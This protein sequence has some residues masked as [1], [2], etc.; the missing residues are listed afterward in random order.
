LSEAVDDGADGSPA[1]GAEVV[2]LGPVPPG[3][4]P[5][6]VEAQRYESNTDQTHFRF[7]ATTAPDGTWTATPI[8]TNAV[9]PTTTTG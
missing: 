5:I 1:K 7:V 6:E 2:L 8:E 9:A 3:A 4:P